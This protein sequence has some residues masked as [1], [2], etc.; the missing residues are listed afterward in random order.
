MV[1]RHV[2]GLLCRFRLHYDPVCRNP[3]PL[4]L[5]SALCGFREGYFL[6]CAE[7]TAVIWSYVFL[8]LCL[9]NSVI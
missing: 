5:G 7:E 9:P 2:H 1:H 3:G 4:E 8:F 6:R